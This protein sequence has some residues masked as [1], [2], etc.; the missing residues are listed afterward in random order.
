MA[1]ITAGKLGIICV[2]IAAL[3]TASCGSSRRTFGLEEGWEVLGERKVNFVR[4]RDEIEVKSRNMFT[5]IRFKVEDRDVRINDLKVTFQNG[6]KLEPAVDDV[7]S[8][9]Q[10]SRVIELARDGRYIDKVSF[11]YRTTGNILSGRA[12]VLVIGKRYYPG[13]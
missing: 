1:R 9:N 7:I 2:L 13:Y 3:V 11:R 5:D 10:Y 4:D 6:D 12:N 8:A